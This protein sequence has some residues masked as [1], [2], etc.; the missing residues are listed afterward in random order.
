MKEILSSFGSEF[1]RP[2]LTLFLPGALGCTP[3]AVCVLWAFPEVRTFAAANHSEAIAMFVLVSLF[4]G[5]VFESVGT[6]FEISWDANA[7]PQHREDWFVYLS[8]KFAPEPVGHRHLRTVVLHL[9]F[10]WLLCCRNMGGSVG[11]PLAD[12][13]FNARHLCRCRRSDCILLLS[14]CARKSR[15]GSRVKARTPRSIE[16]SP[17]ERQVSHDDQRRVTGRRH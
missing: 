9:K 8:Q 6:R 12:H 15:Y 16:P 7:G 1:L 10:E 5:F 13:L 17:E 4:L 11:S 2:L 3:V 14:R